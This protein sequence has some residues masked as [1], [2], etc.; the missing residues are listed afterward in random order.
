[1]GPTSYGVLTCVLNMH[2]RVDA[3]IMPSP[4]LCIIIYGGW[5]IWGRLSDAFRLHCNLNQELL[6][7]QSFSFEVVITVGFVYIKDFSFFA[8]F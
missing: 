6:I 1:M 4:C 7:Y 8:P 3:D 5:V 2:T